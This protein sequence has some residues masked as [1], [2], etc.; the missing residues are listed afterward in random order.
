MILFF[1][2]VFAPYLLANGSGPALLERNLVYSSWERAAASA[3]EQGFDVEFLA[4]TA[5]DRDRS[6]VPSFARPARPLVHYALDARG[7]VMPTIGEIWVSVSR[8]LAISPWATNRYIGASALFNHF[9]PNCIE[10]N[11]SLLVCLRGMITGHGSKRRP[12]PLFSVYE[13][14][15]WS[16]A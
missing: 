5:N 1:T 10:I 3:R 9:L 11:L 14:G 16:S 2:H 4:C 6:A 15:Y 8:R 13:H 7:H 12:R